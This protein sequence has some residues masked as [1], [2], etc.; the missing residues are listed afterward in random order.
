MNALMHF[1][2]DQQR[3][4]RR[5]R[6]RGRLC[7]DLYDERT[8][9]REILVCAECARSTHAGALSTS[10]VKTRALITDY[11]FVLIVRAKHSN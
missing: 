5:G 6:R 10:F 3:G 8:R 9:Y 1:L 2:F 11:K 7:T 4:R